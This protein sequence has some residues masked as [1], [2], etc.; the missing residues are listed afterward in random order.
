MLIA[1]GERSGI[2]DIDDGAEDIPS[3][4]LEKSDDEEDEVVPRHDTNF[5]GELAPPEVADSATKLAAFLNLKDGAAVDDFIKTD[6]IFVHYFNEFKLWLSNR[7]S[8]APKKQTQL[9]ATQAAI[10]A[11][12]QHRRFTRVDQVDQQTWDSLE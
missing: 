3:A 5:N 9:G 11:G 12:A 2:W 4:V 7:A 10:R 8:D 1:L 6:D